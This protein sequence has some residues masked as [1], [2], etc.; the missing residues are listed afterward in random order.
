MNIPATPDPFEEELRRHPMRGVPAVWRSEV[1]AAATKAAAT[2][3]PAEGIDRAAAAAARTQ[4]FGRD[5]QF[6]TQSRRSVAG[7]NR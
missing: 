1:L 4:L 5:F 3:A 6:G 7:S 2:P